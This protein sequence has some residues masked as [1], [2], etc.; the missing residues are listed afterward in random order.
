MTFFVTKE[1]N[2]YRWYAVSSTAFRD[3]D[4]E[5][6]S[7]K[8]LTDDVARADAT[9]DYGPMVWWHMPHV[10]IGQCDFN[11]MVGKSLIESGTFTNSIVAKAMATHAADLGLSIGYRHP[12]GEPDSN[13]V[14]QTIQRFER[15]ILP[16]DQA[17][18]IFTN[19]A[20]EVPVSIKANLKK[21]LTFRDLV[22]DDAQVEAFL[23]AVVENE[24]AAEDAGI[25]S[26]ETK[27]VWDTAY[28]NDLPD[29]SFLF[30]EAG[31]DKD[32][33]GKTIPRTLRHFPYK[34][35][36]GAVDLAHLRNA[37]SRIP[38][39]TAAGLNKDQ[40]Q[41]EARAMLE[42]AQS[43]KADATAPM[44]AAAAEPMTETYTMDDA[45]CAKIADMVVAKLAPLLQ[46][47]SQK[48]T[49]D[50]AQV[51]EQVNAVKS[52]SENAALLIAALKAELAAKEAATSD[53]ATRI[54]SLEGDQPAGYGFQA[55]TAPSTVATKSYAPPSDNGLMQSVEFLMG[56]R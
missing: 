24:Q 29:S 12:M 36:S 54:K 49:T 45:T 22:G 15:S 13:G 30:I 34:D 18:N 33:D 41:Q 3:R 39:S 52:A 6:I 26:K 25:A 21:L 8:A 5:I 4:G 1:Q 19:L 42:Q 35:A 43:T 14:F 40:L 46:A 53:L 17:S 38:Q 27:A 48:A 16:A 2:S 10:I 56:T 28:V 7:T 23:T 20:V 44:D 11:M 50:V 55:S 37:I 51:Q 32:A 47:S 31:G 9:K